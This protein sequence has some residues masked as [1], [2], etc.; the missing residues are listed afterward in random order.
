[1]GNEI[2]ELSNLIQIY[3]KDDRGTVNNP[4][5]EIAWD[6]DESAENCRYLLTESLYRCNL[7]SLFITALTHQTFSRHTVTSKLDHNLYRLVLDFINSNPFIPRASSIFSDSPSQSGHSPH[8]P[9][10]NSFIF[11]TYVCLRHRKF[12]AASLSRSKH[13]G[14]SLV[15]ALFKNPGGDWTHCGVLQDIIEFE[16]IGKRYRVAY[17]H[18]FMPWAGNVPQI[19][20][21]LQ[22]VYLL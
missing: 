12:S 21:D 10:K 19:W 3:T 15:Q 4:I 7:T 22:V 2:A 13:Q 14:S 1:M 8:P 18:W 5:V 20:L 16:H 9:L 17:I 11:Y 6:A